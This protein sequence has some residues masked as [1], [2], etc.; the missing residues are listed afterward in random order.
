MNKPIATPVRTNEILKQFDLTAKKSFGQNFIIDSTVVEKIASCAKLDENCA[1]IEIG[2][3]I[4]A[5][6]E[7]LVK[8]AKTVI[9]Y[10]IDKDLIEVLKMTLGDYANL[11]VRM[12]DF[13]EIDLAALVRQLREDHEKV[14]ICSNL[15]YYI[16][17]SILMKIFQCEERIDT[18]TVMMQKEVADHFFIEPGNK[19]YGAINVIMQCGYEVRRI[20]K[21]SKT[22]FDPKPNVESAVIQFEAKDEK[23]PERNRKQFYN[24]VKACFKQRRKSLLNNYGEYLQ[25][26]EKAKENLH[27]AD[28]DPSLRAEALSLSQF[29]ALF[30]VENKGEQDEE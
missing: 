5:L 7:Q 4:G 27:L 30:E 13:L 29:L 3:G 2:P 18:V 23:V 20:M 16:T 26:R 24:L 11:Q 15:P 12:Q 8:R 9:A 6:S 19:D 22:V 14:V 10:E 21:V 1:V 25:N 17:T 28:L